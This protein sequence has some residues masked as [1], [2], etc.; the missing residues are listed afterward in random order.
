VA[1]NAGNI[2]SQLLDK[3]MKKK[4][5]ALVNGAK[6]GGTAPLT[7]TSYFFSWRL[8]RRRYVLLDALTDGAILFRLELR[9]EALRKRLFCEIHS[10]VGYL[11]LNFKD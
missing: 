10:R 4:H 9:R 7:K 5:G 6:L 11:V 2:L 3:K 1:K 8:G